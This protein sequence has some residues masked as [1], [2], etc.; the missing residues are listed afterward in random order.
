M[1][2]IEEAITTINTFQPAIGRFFLNERTLEEHSRMLA[3]PPQVPSHILDRQEMY[4]ELIVRKVQSLFGNS[5]PF[6]PP[7]KR[8]PLVMS[9]LEHH[10]LVNSSYHTSSSLILCFS[11]LFKRDQEADVFALS[12]GNIPLNNSSY[13]RGV[14]FRRRH[15]NLFPNSLHNRLVLAQKATRFRLAI[16]AHSQAHEQSLRAKNRLPYDRSD[17]EFLKFLDQEILEKHQT[18]AS[19]A[20]QCTIWNYHLASLL[21]VPSMRPRM[22]RLF[23][24]QRENIESQLLISVLLNQ[25]D[26]F[27]YKMICEPNVRELALQLFDGLKGCWDL[28]H[29]TGTVFF[30]ALNEK[31]E[32]LSL[33]PKKDELHSPDGS[34]K[35]KLTAENLAEYLKEGI[36]FPSTFLTHMLAVFWAGIKCLGGI[37]QYF[38]LARYQ[39]KL[40]ELLGYIG[41]AD[42]NFVESIDLYTINIF[43][44]FFEK[45]GKIIREKD[46]WDVMGDGGL[47]EHYL[48]V[49]RQ[50]AIKDIVMPLLP[51]YYRAA[52][53]IESQKPFSFTEEEL[54][55]PLHQLFAHEI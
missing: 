32:R 19:Y 3:R 4:R 46:A 51:M 23:I 39:E 28:T 29:Q 17:L 26:S 27:L 50:L 31:G 6:L 36:I 33:F 1:N 43:S 13:K 38:Y 34:I 40:I 30:L 55:R 44:I 42:R 48:E 25:P 14:E 11:R 5:F 10:G 15:L 21:V 45:Q 20:D 9:T 53:P 12:T 16:L 52:V 24:L 7:E 35:V 37:S 2:S 18:G 22:L 49:L 41:D 47:P 8:K 54:S